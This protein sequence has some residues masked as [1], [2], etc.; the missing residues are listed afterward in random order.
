MSLTSSTVSHATLRTSSMTSFSW[1]PLL[2]LALAPPAA[3]ADPDPDPDPDPS[4]TTRTSPAAPSPPSSGISADL[5]ANEGTTHPKITAAPRLKGN[6]IVGSIVRLHGGRYT[7]GSLTSVSFYRCA[8]KC[9]LVRSSRSRS[10]RLS[11]RVERGFVRARVIVSGEGGT[12]SVWA[13]GKVGPV[14]RRR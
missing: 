8:P 7:G 11:D 5:R 6:P 4:F 2:P 14:H 13:A 3:D 12:I 9:T 1:K 10:Y